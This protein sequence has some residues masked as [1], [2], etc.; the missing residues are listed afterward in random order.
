MAIQSFA[1][2]ATE[3]FYY[4]GKSAHKAGWSNVSDTVKRKLDQ[5]SAATTLNDL[6][7]PPNN[8]LEALKEN[9]A[10]HH[11][12]RINNQWRLVFEWTNQGPS[13]VQVM[14]YH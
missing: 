3:N 4:T 13:N 2:S 8:K 11:S 6:K 5:L 12:I 10:G 9:L 7:M 14:D 1:D